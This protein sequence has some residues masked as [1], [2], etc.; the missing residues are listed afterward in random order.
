M[1]WGMLG[2]FTYLTGIGMGIIIA[3]P[4]MMGIGAW[5]GRKSAHKILDK[6]MPNWRKR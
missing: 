4:L 2:F 3:L 1:S 6:Y 5:S